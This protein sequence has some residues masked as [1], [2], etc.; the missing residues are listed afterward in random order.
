MLSNAIKFSK[1]H[2]TIKI[3]VAT[4]LNNENSAEIDLCVKVIDTGMGIAPQDLQKLFQPFFRTTDAANKDK[5]KN[6]HGLGLSICKRIVMGMG[7]TLSVT[8]EIGVGT[9]FTIKLT[10]QMYDRKSEL[11]KVSGQSLVKYFR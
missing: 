2:D 11:K 5:N 7:G 1:F 3:D 9:T 10:T 6:G 8:S 4:T